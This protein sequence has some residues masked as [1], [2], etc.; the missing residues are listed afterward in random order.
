MLTFS[1]FCN[2]LVPN[3][4][5]GAVSIPVDSWGLYPDCLPTATKQQIIPMV[6]PMIPILGLKE[7]QG[8]KKNMPLAPQGTASTKSI[9]GKSV[10]E[11]LIK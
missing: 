9:A 7:D 6:L 5:A 3:H 8:L 4:R 2:I 11:L 1:L 10:Q